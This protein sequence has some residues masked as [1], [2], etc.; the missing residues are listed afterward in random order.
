MSTDQ[1]TGELPF[2][3]T[4]QGTYAR[5]PLLRPRPRPLFSLLGD[6][7]C[8]LHHFLGSLLLTRYGDGLCFCFL[9]RVAKPGNNGHH[10]L[11]AAAGRSEPVTGDMGTQKE[12]VILQ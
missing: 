6:V 5:L 12:A 3:Q 7:I 2:E 10:V 1:R 11:Q 4:K 9:L 8:F